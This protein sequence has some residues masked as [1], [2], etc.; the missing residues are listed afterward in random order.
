[1]HRYSTTLTPKFHALPCEEG[2]QGTP[3][4]SLCVL[5][6]HLLEIVDMAS[7]LC[8]AAHQPDVNV[9]DAKHALFELSHEAVQTHAL[10]ALWHEEA[11]ATW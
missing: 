3:K 11:D 5:Y 8:M 4:H 10:F 6:A 2:T 1:M 7:N 9:R